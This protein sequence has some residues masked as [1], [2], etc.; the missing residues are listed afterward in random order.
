MME[1]TSLCFHHAFLYQQWQR[2]YAVCR[3]ELLRRT[4][5]L[6]VIRVQLCDESGAVC[7]ALRMKRWGV[8][9]QRGL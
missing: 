7:S 3:F 5:V 8:G 1:S 9:Q 2:G 4:L 6:L